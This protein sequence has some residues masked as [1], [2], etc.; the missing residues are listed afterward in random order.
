[1]ET[2]YTGQFK[3]NYVPYI[4]ERRAERLAKFPCYIKVL[5]L[6]RFFLIYFTIGGVKKIVCYTEEFII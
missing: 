1:M 3:I 2:C 6:S 5:L 4:V